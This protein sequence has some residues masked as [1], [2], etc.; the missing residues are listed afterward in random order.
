MRLFFGL[1]PDPATA[2][3]I[4]DW[5]DR[6]FPGFARPVPPANFHITLAYLGEI[7]SREVE[8]LCEKVDQIFT[9][10]AAA[11]LLQLDRTG[12]WPRPGIYWLGPSQWPSSI[13]V[14]S[15]RLG[16]TGAG[17]P[18]SKSHSR[19]IPHISLFR[20][21]KSAPPAAAV[22]PDFKFRFDHI[23]LFESRQ[24]RSGVSYEPLE[25]WELSPR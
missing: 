5:R 6:Q 10:P 9:S 16:N 13:D 19:F 24:G 12:Y 7:Q 25:H 23:T 15:K 14:L 11:G 21:C 1:E 20:A 3:Q 18:S 17:G 4:S 22:E 8:R 2:L